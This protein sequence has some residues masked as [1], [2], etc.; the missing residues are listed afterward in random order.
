MHFFTQAIQHKYVSIPSNWISI[1]AFLGNAIKCTK[2]SI[3]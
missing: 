3:S 1:T 2:I